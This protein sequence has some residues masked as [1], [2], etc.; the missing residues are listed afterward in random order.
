M[1]T[2]IIQSMGILDSW[3]KNE[4]DG[5]IRVFWQHPPGGELPQTGDSIAVNGV[6]L[7]ALGISEQGFEADVSAETLNITTLGTLVPGAAL[8]LESSLRA[9]Q[10]LGGHLVTGHI[11]GIGSVAAIDSI[12]ESRCFCIEMP[13][14]VQSCVAVKGSVAVDGVSLTVNEVTADRFEV[15]IIPHTL[16]NTRFG[17]YANG[18][19][20][21]LEV[22]IIARYV[23]RQL[24]PM[25]K[26]C[27]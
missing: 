11:D 5:T 18:D 13:A 23:E 24:Q 21:N 20:V 17:R 12:G 25:Q 10:P 15:N 4:V 8:N 2:G 9:G 14:A 3:Q 26:P 6:C 1:F 22:D 27:P 16:Q 19:R 7:T